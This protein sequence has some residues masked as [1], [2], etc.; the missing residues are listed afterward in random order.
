MTLRVQT[1]RIDR[2]K[3]LKFGDLLGNSYNHV[4]TFETLHYPCVSM[5]GSEMFKKL[6]LTC[7]KSRM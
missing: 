1:E 3:Y 7:C 5:L 4:N 2:G 6:H